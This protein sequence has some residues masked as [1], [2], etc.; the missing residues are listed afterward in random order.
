M[1]VCLRFISKSLNITLVKIVVEYIIIIT[2][3][4]LLKDYNSSNVTLA[5]TKR[6]TIVQLC[7]TITTPIQ[8]NATLSLELSMVL[9]QICLVVDLTNYVVVV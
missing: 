2:I 1:K 7:T 8:L 9:W 6:K 3:V 5:N 4:K